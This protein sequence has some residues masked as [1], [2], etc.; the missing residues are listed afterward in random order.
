MEDIQWKIITFKIF[1]ALSHQEQHISSQF[2]ERQQKKEIVWRQKS[3][4]QW[5][6][7]GEHNTKLFHRWMIQRRHS[8][9]ITQLK[10]SQGNKLSSHQDIEYELVIFF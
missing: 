7:V 1:E 5:L 4:I 9:H 8:N 10:N 2:D 3:Y 6:K